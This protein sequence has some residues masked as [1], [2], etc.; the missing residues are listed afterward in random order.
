MKPHLKKV[1]GKTYFLKCKGN[2]E[3]FYKIGITKQKWRERLRKI[4][5]KTTILS[6]FEGKLP[7]CTKLEIKLKKYYQK[8]QYRPKIYFA[9]VAECFKFNP[10]KIKE[11]K[12]IIN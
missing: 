4:P 2:G 5:Y 3:N 1:I 9:G 6:F 8:Y 12:K 11:I 10:N 7:D